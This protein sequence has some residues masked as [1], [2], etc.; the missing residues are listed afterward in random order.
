[1]EYR[2]KHQP[3]TNER[4]KKNTCIAWNSNREMIFHELNI[5]QTTRKTLYQ[6][7]IQE[8]WCWVGPGVAQCCDIFFIFPPLRDHQAKTR[9]KAVFW[10]RYT[11]HDAL[12][13]ATA[14]PASGFF[15]SIF[16][17]SFGRDCMVLKM[18]HPVDEL[19]LLTRESWRMK[20][21]LISFP[22]FQ[23]NRVV[24]IWI[25]SLCIFALTN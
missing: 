18:Q 7:S 21:K 6:Q 10:E 23:R 3:R 16:R 2:S 24:C 15:L 12:E 5:A 8:W 11:G 17:S 22:A 19:K 13:I 4:E 25:L 20:N 9:L 1:M 14:L